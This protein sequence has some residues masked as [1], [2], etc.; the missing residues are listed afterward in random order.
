M[1]F[2]V[3]NSE[4]TYIIP[5]FQGIMDL[6]LTRVHKKHHADLI[7]QHIKDIHDYKLEQ[8]IMKPR[9]RY[10]NTILKAIKVLEMDEAATRIKAQE[11]NRKMMIEDQR[12]L[13]QYEKISRIKKELNIL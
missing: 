6:D 8:A 2:N 12:R 4:K 3:N 11:K 7:K 13:E 10:E 1:D 5:G 9:L